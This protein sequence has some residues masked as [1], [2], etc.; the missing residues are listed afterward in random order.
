MIVIKLFSVILTVHSVLSLHSIED[1]F[2][3][4]ELI[5]FFDDVSVDI[6]DEIIAAAISKR[7]VAVEIEDKRFA[8]LFA[9]IN[10]TRA[11]HYWTR[12]RGRDKETTSGIAWEVYYT[13]Y[14]T[15]ALKNSITVN[16]A[17]KKRETLVRLNKVSSRFKRD[18]KVDDTTENTLMPKENI[19]DELPKPF[20][21][22]HD[23]MNI[24]GNSHVGHKEKKFNRRFGRK[25]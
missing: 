16:E 23:R 14:P 2:L 20:G 13:L 12:K 11:N 7:G 9:P 18:V 19:T 3:T 1:K 8:S 22:S 24:D 21:H 25:L 15:K 17:R 5:R 4:K 6:S 10:L